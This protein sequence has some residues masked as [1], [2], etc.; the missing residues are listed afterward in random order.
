M[1]SV[2][3]FDHLTEAKLVKYCAQE[4]HNIKTINYIKTI[5][6]INFSC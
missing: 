4:E 2:Q 5:K 3:Q 6:N 1:G